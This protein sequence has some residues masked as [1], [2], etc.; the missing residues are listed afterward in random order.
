MSEHATGSAAEIAPIRLVGAEPT[1]LSADDLDALPLETKEIEVVCASGAR[2]TAAWRGIP[3]GKLLETIGVPSES[4]HVVFESADGHRSCVDVA[5]AL[6]GLIAFS[7]DGKPLSECA[8]Y[9]S[10]FV[11][12]SVDGTR[13]TKAVREIRATRLPPESSPNSNEN[14]GDDPTFGSDR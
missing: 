2:Y 13:M 4:T 8:G 12:P 10:R 7:R 11:A 1:V 14:I 5:A 9:D 3:V 6:G